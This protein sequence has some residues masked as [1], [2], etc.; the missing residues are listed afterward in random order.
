[1]GKLTI[2]K[3]PIEGLYV[4]DTAAFIDNRGAF[5]RW[6]CEAELKEI[7]GNRYIKNVNFSRTIKKGSVRG[8]HFQRPPYAEMKLIRCIKGA[9]LDVAVDLRANSDT[10]YKWYAIEL[11]AK[12]MKMFVIP[13]GFAHG[14]QTLTDDAEMLY[15]HTHFYNMDCEGAVRYDDPKIGI[16]WSLG[17]TDISE[18][19][20]N[21]PYIDDNF[22]GISL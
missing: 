6:F 10:K 16:K 5:A 2:S 4:V 14:F 22:E 17:V 20:A 11:S 7:I 13:E 18:K 21:H 12:N 8:M 15:L 3:T 1:M 9:V 19:D